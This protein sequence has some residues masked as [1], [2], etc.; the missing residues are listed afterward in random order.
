MHGSGERLSLGKAGRW[1]SPQPPRFARSMT[2]VRPRA[3]QELFVPALIGGRDESPRRLRRSRQ[4]YGARGR[5]RGA[6]R[7]S[8]LPRGSGRAGP[9]P[10]ACVRLVREVARV[11]V[12]GDYDR[13]AAEALPA[14]DLGPLRGLA[15]ATA[16]LTQRD[17]T[18][19]DRAYL[20]ALPRWAITAEPGPRCLLVHGTPTDVLSGAVNR[21]AP[22]LVG[23]RR[24]RARRQHPRRP[25]PSSVQPH[26]GPL[27][28]G[29]PGQRRL[30]PGSRAHG[31]VRGDR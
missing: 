29:V 11:A 28:R 1:S 16:P 9:Q 7:P 27:T 13:A 8:S 17:L 18:D 20:G 24:R 25:D 12:Q 31:R 5:A 19:A 10:G 6:P 21:S 30:A 26:G 15:D 22:G 4:S 3:G 2:P 23:G 14:T